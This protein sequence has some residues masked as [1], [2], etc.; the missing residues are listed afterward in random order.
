MGDTMEFVWVRLERP[1]TNSWLEGHITVPHDSP[2]EF[3]RLILD[4]VVECI[5]P[6]WQL[7]TY[8]PPEEQGSDKR[9][10]NAD[11]LEE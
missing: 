8:C 2:R 9:P 7:V 11:P 4:D 5:L 1:S 3:M 10:V 6:G